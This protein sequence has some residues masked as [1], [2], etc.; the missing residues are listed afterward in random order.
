MAQ[1]DVTR[2]L[3]AILT[4]DVVGYSRPRAFGYDMDSVAL[5]PGAS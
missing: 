2:K 3:A 1:Q 4:A 5:H